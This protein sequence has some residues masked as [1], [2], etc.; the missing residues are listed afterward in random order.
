MGFFR[1]MIEKQKEIDRKKIEEA[2]KERSEFEKRKSEL[3]EQGEVYCPKCLSIKLSANKK[4]YDIKKGILLGGVGGFIGKD[5][6]EITC[7]K[8]GSKFKPGE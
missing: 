3:D 1:K 6:I 2:R 8:C 7:L 5:K 4:G